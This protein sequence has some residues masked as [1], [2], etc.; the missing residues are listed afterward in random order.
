MRFYG[1]ED[2]DIYLQIAE[3][4][5]VVEECA[6]PSPDSLIQL[7]ISTAGSL[8]NELYNYSGVNA[9]DFA[10]VGW[11]MLT[12]PEKPGEIYYVYMRGSDGPVPPPAAQ[13]ETDVAQGAAGLLAGL[14][15][16]AGLGGNSNPF[17]YVYRKL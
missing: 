1:S 4:N 17:I 3:N 16:G 2:W 5:W 14:S 12:A 15:G 8:G 11:H 10:D 9:G 13:K 7:A 6:A